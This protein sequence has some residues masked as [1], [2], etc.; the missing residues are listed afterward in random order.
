LGR[1]GNV[2]QMNFK[3]YK[4]MMQCDTIDEWK[5]HMWDKPHRIIGWVLNEFGKRERIDSYGRTRHIA[6][7]G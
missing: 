2:S 4:H 3:C 5:N 1:K 6:R 7:R